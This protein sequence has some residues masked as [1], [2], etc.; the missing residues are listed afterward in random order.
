[1]S[2]DIVKQ[3]DDLVA[4]KTF[5]LDALEG[6]KAIKD[7]HQR[8]LRDLQTKTEMLD[9]KREQIVAMGEE[10]NRKQA[11]IDELQTKVKCMSQLASDGD[12]AIWEKKIA[13]ASAAAYK[14]ALYTVFKPS[15]VRETIQRNHTVM[16]PTGN[17]GGYPQAVSNQD[18]IVREDA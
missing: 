9:L 7:E 13:E 8:V 16:V 5:S 2:I 17:G 12:A 18:I 14:D 6:I 1:M 15:A 10:L 4:S 3:I 11:Q